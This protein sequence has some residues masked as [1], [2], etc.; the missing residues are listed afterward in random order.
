MSL[1]LCLSGRLALDGKME[2]LYDVMI[3]GRGSWRLVCRGF[4]VSPP[5]VPLE[6]ESHDNKDSNIRCRCCAR[7]SQ[8]LHEESSGYLVPSRIPESSDEEV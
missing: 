3:L 1:R 5:V 6:D 7:E 2:K 8:P 4:F